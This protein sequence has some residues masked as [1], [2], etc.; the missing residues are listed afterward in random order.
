MDVRPQNMVYQTSSFGAVCYLPCSATRL[1]Q[2]ALTSCVDELN[3][4]ENMRLISEEHS[5]EFKLSSAY[6]SIFFV[7]IREF[8]HFSAH[9]EG[10][11]NAKDGKGTWHL[12]GVQV[13][14]PENTRIRA[15]TK[16]C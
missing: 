5:A 12:S 14:H 7:D 6:S 16:R 8:T 10:C 2:H 4:E 1:S 3:C 13:V 15:L 11:P 9:A